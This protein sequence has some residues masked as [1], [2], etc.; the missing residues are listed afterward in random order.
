MVEHLSVVPTP[1]QAWQERTSGLD[2]PAELDGHRIDWA[3]WKRQIRILGDHGFDQTCED[4]GADVDQQAHT[5]GRAPAP[6]GRPGVPM[7][8]YRAEACLTCRYVLV[9]ELFQGDRFRVELE[10]R[11]VWSNRS[12]QVLL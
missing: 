12:Q 8:R 9:N 4:C 6:W 3:P 7:V 2:L 5:P 11:E 10:P 1:E